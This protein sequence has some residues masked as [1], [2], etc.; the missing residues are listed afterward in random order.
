MS[1]NQIALLQA[2]LI[3]FQLVNAGLAGLAHINPIITIILSAFVGGMQA[4]M[5]RLGNQSVSPQV[6][7]MLTDEQM[8]TLPGKPTKPVS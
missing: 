8:A 7:A 2:V 4:F 5:Q 1:Q 3:F 6:A